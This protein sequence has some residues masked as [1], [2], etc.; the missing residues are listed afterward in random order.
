MSK[1]R[2]ILDGKTYEMEVE[3]VSENGTVE[4]RKEDKGNNGVSQNAPVVKNTPTTQSS[5]NAAAGTVIAPMP[6]TVIKIVK[7]EGQT[8]KSGDVVL[9]LEAMKME[10]EIVSPADGTILSMKCT[11]GGTVAGG[12]I[13]FEVK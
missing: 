8:V 3:L 9:V 13:L 12:E 6:G 7:G 10:N 2:I 11:E 5:T 1:Y 4:P